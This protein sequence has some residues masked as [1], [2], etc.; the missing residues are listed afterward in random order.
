MCQV[1]DNFECSEASSTEFAMDQMP[2]GITCVYDP[3]GEFA[4]KRNMSMIG[5]EKYCRKLL[6]SIGD[7]EIRIYFKVKSFKMRD[8]F[9]R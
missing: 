3:D 2:C 7:W 5:L 4:P 1:N 9:C 8:I 6:Y